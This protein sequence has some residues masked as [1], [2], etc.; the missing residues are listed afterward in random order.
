MSDAA[1]EELIVRHLPLVQA[2]ARRYANRGEPLDDLVQ[3]GTV[4]L[5]KA[6]DRFDPSRGTDLAAFAAPTILGE[7]RRHFRDKAWAVRVP[8]ALQERHALVARTV[9][10]VTGRLGRSPSVAEVA[11][12]CGLSE[13]DVLDAMAA[14]DAYR[15]LTLSPPVGEDDATGIDPGAADPEFDHANDRVA[16]RGGLERLPSRERLILLLRF[17]E[18]LTQSEIAAQVGISQMHVSRLIRRA[19]DALRDEVAEGVWP[20]P[21]PG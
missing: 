16:L 7:I 15:P 8:R 6:V 20:S 2:L 9:E 11:G 3:V 10:E 12:E 18:G 14:G 1:R 21:P 19:L 5:I 4:G 17:R 13:E